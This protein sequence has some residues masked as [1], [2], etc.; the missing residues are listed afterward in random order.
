MVRQPLASAC[1]LVRLCKQ[2]VFRPAR[3]NPRESAEPSREVKS[4]IAHVREQT[5]AAAARSAAAVHVRS[6]AP[7]V[8]HCMQL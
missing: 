5:R 7:A 6:A 1:S 2:V 8:H 4:H 3:A